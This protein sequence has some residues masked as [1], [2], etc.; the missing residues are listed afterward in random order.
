MRISV[1]KKSRWNKKI[2]KL[3]GIINRDKKCEWNKKTVRQ[4]GI[5]R[6]KKWMEQEDSEADGNKWRQEE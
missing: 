6:Y 3:I 2:V 4:I 1:D 5:R